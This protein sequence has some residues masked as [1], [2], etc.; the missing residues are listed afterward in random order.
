MGILGFAGII[1][2]YASKSAQNKFDV[3]GLK[4]EVTEIKTN[5]ATKENV[6]NISDSL[7]I[8]NIIIRNDVKSLS[9]KSDVITRQL[10][11]HIAKTVTPDSMRKIME[12]LYEKKN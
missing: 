7:R 10:T 1:W 2:T 11:R 3:A 12:E 5:M 9:L 6:K 8:S 4:K